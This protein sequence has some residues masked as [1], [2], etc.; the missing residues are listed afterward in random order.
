[1]LATVEPFRGWLWD[2]RWQGVSTTGM[3]GVRVAAKGAANGAAKGL[4]T[5]IVA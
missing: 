2:H 4:S 5:G 3:S 1:M